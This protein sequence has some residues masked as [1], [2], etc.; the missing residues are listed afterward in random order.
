MAVGAHGPAG[1]PEPIAFWGCGRSA[2]LV[3]GPCG[4]DSVG[5]AGVIGTDLSAILAGVG[6]IG[7]WMTFGASQQNFWT[8][9]CA[10]VG[11]PELERDPR[12][13]SNIA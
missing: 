2:L 12:F 1:V 9:L 5:L 11:A 8:K 10:I 3:C 7:P 6:G 4:V 13:S